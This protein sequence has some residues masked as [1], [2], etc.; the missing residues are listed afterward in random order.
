MRWWGDTK[1]PGAGLAGGGEAGGGIGGERNELLV[2]AA[3][4]GQLDD[5]LV[6][7]NGAEGGAFGGQQRDGA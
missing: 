5:A 7:D 1:K 3:V 4:G 6:F 2:V